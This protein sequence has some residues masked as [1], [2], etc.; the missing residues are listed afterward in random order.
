MAH[1][2][3]NASA[4]PSSGYTV[5]KRLR[6]VTTC[7]LSDLR[8]RKLRNFPSLHEVGLW[9]CID[10]EHGTQRRMAELQWGYL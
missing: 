1:S 5:G 10:R 7:R 4:S 2:F 6:V 3:Y 8:G 9:L